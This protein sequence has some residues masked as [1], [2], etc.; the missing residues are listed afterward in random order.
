MNPRAS[1]RRSLPHLGPWAPT[2]A[3][4]AP[5]SSPLEVLDPQPAFDQV[6]SDVV[7]AAL[8]AVGVAA[9]GV[10]V[11]LVATPMTVPIATQTSCRRDVASSCHSGTTRRSPHGPGA[12][13]G[14]GGHRATSRC[15]SRPGRGPT[16]R[17]AAGPARTGAAPRRSARRA[18]RAAPGRSTGAA[19]AG[20][21]PPRTR[22]NVAA[23]RAVDLAGA[24]ASASARQGPSPRA[25]CS[26]S[27]GPRAS[28][29]TRGSPLG[30][31]PR[32]PSRPVGAGR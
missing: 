2:S 9:Q 20:S 29:S 26:S 16:D 15:R 3:V 23:G 31:R 30:H 24:R 18:P 11:R 27:A 22:A 21:A 6:G 4:S 17:P 1:S 25:V 12:C 10:G 28:S 19:C 13:T 14:R 32:P 7:E 5:T 8:V